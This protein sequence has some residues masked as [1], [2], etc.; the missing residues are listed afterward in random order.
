MIKSLTHKKQTFDSDPSKLPATSR[1]LPA[2]CAIYGQSKVE[3][4]CARYHLFPSVKQP[5]LFQKPLANKIFH[6]LLI[7]LHDINSHD[8]ERFITKLKTNAPL[9]KYETDALHTLHTINPAHV[10]TLKK[11]SSI[12]TLDGDLLNLL[13]TTLKEPNQSY[14]LDKLVDLEKISGLPGKYIKHGWFSHK[15]GRSLEDEERLKI[16]QEI[17]SLAPT[18]HTRYCEILA[19][20]LVKKHLYYENNHTH[21][22]HMGMLI[23]GLKGNDGHPRWYR[24]DDIMDSGLGKFAYRLVPATQDYAVDMPDIVLYRSTASLPTASDALSSTLTDFNIRPPGYLGRYACLTQECAWLAKATPSPSIETTRPLL[25][26]G[27]S[28]GAATSQLALINLQRSGQ[29]PNRKISLELFDSPAIDAHDVRRFAKTW[30]K[31]KREVSPELSFNYHVSKDDPVPLAGALWNSSYLGNFFVD[32]EGN[33]ISQHYQV[34]AVVHKQALTDVGAKNIAVSGI[35]GAHGRMFYRGKEN[36]DYIDQR[37]SIAEYDRSVKW[38]RRLLNSTFKV[39][40]SILAWTF[41]APPGLLKRFLFGRRHHNA[42]IS[43]IGT[44]IKNFVKTKNVS[45]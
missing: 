34:S 6:K 39:V 1:S 42:I 25:I 14:K 8:I 21:A 30:I 22:R 38:R 5:L 43:D 11:C 3:E 18:D 9:S 12:T 40:G 16:Y 2:L 4:V 19:K 44:N 37:V 29:W 28:L 27:H 15:K 33:D 26:T 35:V 20:I 32:E 24:V 7:G 10:T 45:G 36:I 41:I 13:I 17:D 23:P 31:Q